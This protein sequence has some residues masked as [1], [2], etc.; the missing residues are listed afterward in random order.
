MMRTTKTMLALL[1][2]SLAGHLDCGT[3]L[4]HLFGMHCGQE[5]RTI[6]APFVTD[7]FHKTDIVRNLQRSGG[8]NNSAWPQPRG[9]FDM[10]QR[11]HG[12]WLFIHYAQL[13]DGAFL[14][15]LAGRAPDGHLEVCG[16]PR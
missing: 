3:S 4:V 14:P 16:M 13:L 11:K 8:A 2:V 10:R 9:R 1:G 7:N 12:R 15:R 5:E 6:W